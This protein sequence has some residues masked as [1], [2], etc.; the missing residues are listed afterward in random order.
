M[1]YNVSAAGTTVVVNGTNIT[2][3]ADDVAPVTVSDVEVGNGEKSFSGAMLVWGVEKSVK[4]EISVIPDSQSDYILYNLAKAEKSRIATNHSYKGF[5]I[6][7]KQDDK[8]KGTYNGCIFASIPAGDVLATSGR[9]N[10]R[11]YTFLG[12]EAN[13]GIEQQSQQVAM[14]WNA[15]TSPSR[16]LA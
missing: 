16:N 9:K 8:T 10:G 4:I 1:G 12:D 5:S 11:K 2:D 13:R 7:I 14:I 15:E 3:F 6:V